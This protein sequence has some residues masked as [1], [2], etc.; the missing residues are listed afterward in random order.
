MIFSFNGGEAILTMA[1]EQRKVTLDL[2]SYSIDTITRSIGGKYETTEYT[3]KC[4]STYNRIE[5]KNTSDAHRL[6]WA[7]INGDLEAA[8]LLADEVQLNYLAFKEN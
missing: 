7:V 1:T 5:D 8:L 3:I 6:A 2:I 4:R